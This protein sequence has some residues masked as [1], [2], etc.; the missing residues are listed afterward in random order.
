MLAEH[1]EGRALVQ[2]LAAEKGPQR[3]DSAR[4]YVAVLET[5]TAALLARP[6]ATSTP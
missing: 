6:R 1:A 2:A 4:R 3:V 5:L